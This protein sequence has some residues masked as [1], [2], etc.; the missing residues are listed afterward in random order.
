[1]TELY[2]RIT[3]TQVYIDSQSLR[4]YE[5]LEEKLNDFSVY[6][7]LNNI[8]PILRQMAEAADIANGLSRGVLD[9]RVQF[10]TEIISQYYY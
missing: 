3:P 5:V 1:M 7:Q 9:R 8:S 4:Y 2:S 6:N 10:T